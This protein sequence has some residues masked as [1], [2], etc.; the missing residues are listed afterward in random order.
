MINETDSKM[1]MISVYVDQLEER[2]ATFAVARRDIN[3]REGVCIEIEEREKQMSKDFSTLEKQIKNVTKSR[4]ELQVLVDSMTDQCAQLE[5]EKKTLSSCKASLLQKEKALHEE[6]HM[7]QDQYQTL[8]ERARE[9]QLTLDKTQQE[10]LEREEN[11]EISKQLNHQSDQEI[12]RQKQLLEETSSQIVSLQE[13]ITTLETENSRIVTLVLTLEEKIES[14]NADAEDK[15]MRQVVLEAERIAEER[16]E[17][18]LIAER[19]IAEE[20]TLDD[21]LSSQDEESNNVDDQPVEDNGQDM[22]EIGVDESQQTSQTNIHDEI[23]E[24]ESFVDSQ[25]FMPPPPPPPPISNLSEDIASDDEN[26]VVD[27]NSVLYP[28]P[29]SEQDFEEVKEP[30]HD[31]S[32]H[33]T[34]AETNVSIEDENYETD[35]SAEFSNGDITQASDNSHA[36]NV[37]DENYRDDGED[38]EIQYDH[39]TQNFD[40]EVTRLEEPRSHDDDFEVISDEE[41]YYPP[42][43]FENHF[44]D[45]EVFTS[46]Y[47][48][49]VGPSRNESE[50]E[51]SLDTN[52]V[53]GEDDRASDSK[54]EVDRASESTSEDDE[55]ENQMDIETEE[56]GESYGEVNEEASL[57]ELEVGVVEGN[58]APSKD[59]KVPFR[60]LRKKFSSL[61][62]V[63]GLFTPASK[64]AAFVVPKPH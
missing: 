54:S 3:V 44:D 24:Y 37:P 31:L 23:E 51:M 59:R 22:Q 62:G 55:S 53:G 61:T 35:I 57:D 60:N 40:G 5:K 58:T 19:R 6:L 2:L 7:L 52:N 47:D 30:M 13:E 1:S 27:E 8:E 34:T 17:S 49:S 10:V 48:D 36:N 4:D 16:F 20:K 56:T 41:S 25:D 14:E 42:G 9:T 50:V 11:L 64:R 39:K 43:Y 28:P 21:A 12:E 46:F 33:E 15:F 18:F 45:E 38:V 32:W 29:F 26:E 63:H